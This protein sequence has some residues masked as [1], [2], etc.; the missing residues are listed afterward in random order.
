MRGL[1]SVGVWLLI[2]ANAVFAVLMIADGHPANALFNI[3]AGA[4]LF[5][6]AFTAEWI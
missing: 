5:I 1:L 4:F 6:A 3:F 2:A